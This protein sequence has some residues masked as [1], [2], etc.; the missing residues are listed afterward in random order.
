MSSTRASA[1]SIAPREGGNERACG[2]S[3]AIRTCQRWRRVRFPPPV[4]VAS[5][6]SSRV[7]PPP[8]WQKFA[9]RSP[10]PSSDCS[11]LKPIEEYEISGDRSAGPSQPAQCARVRPCGSTCPTR[12]LVARPPRAIHAANATPSRPRLASS[13]EHGSL[14]PLASA[15]QRVERYSWGWPSGAIC[16]NS[17]RG[18]WEQPSWGRLCWPRD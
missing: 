1:R 3:I 5:R 14:R 11:M 17:G 7:R 15:S 12:L 6:H 9:C 18:A 16:P 10:P 4:R 13:G 8:K 2:A